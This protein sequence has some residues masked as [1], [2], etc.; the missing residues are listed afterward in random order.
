MTAIE[1]RLGR[2]EGR[3]SVTVVRCD[4]EDWKRRSEEDKRIGPIS[5]F[6]GDTVSFWQFAFRAAA[7]LLFRALGFLRIPNPRTANR[8]LSLFGRSLRSLF[9]IRFASR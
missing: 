3:N 4:R 7:S 8:K 5:Q 1:E 9:V 2:S 6:D